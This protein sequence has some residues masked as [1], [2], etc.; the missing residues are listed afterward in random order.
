MKELGLQTIPLASIDIG[1]RLRPVSEPHA[2]LTAENIQQVGRL[3]QPIEVRQMGDRYG[4]IAGRHR[5]RAIE[6]LGWAT[7]PAFV[8]D[9]TDDEALLAEIDENLV[10]HELNPLDRA[11][12]LAKRKEVYERLHPET[13]AGVAGAE[14][15]HR[16]TEIISFARSTAEKVGLTERTIQLAVSIARDLSPEVRAAIAGTALALKQAELLALARVPA[17]LQLAVANLVLSGTCRNVAAARDAAEGR[18]RDTGT[19]EQAQLNRLLTAWRKA[20]ASARASF[21]AFIQKPEKEAA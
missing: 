9:C 7:I 10:R 15:K 8:F 14:A 3:R 19:E 17:D 5:L 11:V 1:E 6:L 20:G 21:L 13:V 16:A 4:L 12:S 2:A 18:T